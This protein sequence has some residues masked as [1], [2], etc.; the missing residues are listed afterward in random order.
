[1]SFQASATVSGNSVTTDKI[2]GRLFGG[3]VKGSLRFSWGESMSLETDIASEF[4]N[5]P[6]LLTALGMPAVVDGQVDGRV[7][8]SVQA[9]N[10][11]KLVSSVPMEG[12]FLATK[13]SLRG[14]DLVE[15]VRRAG[16]QPYRGG[17]TKFD[18]LKGRFA[19]DGKRLRLS[20][21]D[22]ASGIVS[23]YGAVQIDDEGRIDGD[24]NVMIRASAS[25]TREPVS[26]SGTIKDPLLTAGRQ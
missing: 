13:G 12:D 17:G 6:V 4:M 14:M 24:V 25:R 7:G 11:S 5:T 1:E 16:Q 22:L 10:W 26:F 9:E 3:V 8:F 2:E 15:A 19:W 23:A 21:I 18:T 20:Q